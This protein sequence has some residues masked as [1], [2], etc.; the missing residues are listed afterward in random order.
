M[1]AVAESARVAGFTL[2]ELLVA[3]LIMGLMLGLAVPLL[4]PDATSQLHD[5]AERLARLFELAGNESR[6]S[7]RSLVWTSDGSGYRFWRTDEAVLGSVI[8]DD[9]IWHQHR[10][11]AGM[12][13]SDLSI[14]NLPVRGA[15][16][17]DFA[18]DGA[19]SAFSLDLSQGAS[20]V[21][22]VALPMGDV[23]VVAGTG[24]GHALAARP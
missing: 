5:E 1:V 7:G 22:V 20:Q 11:P 4:R 15:M 10:L 12:H 18:S 2:M 13:L 6:F 9:D 17:L 14:E 8:R 24:M 3:L 21:S 16:R 23:Q 19:V